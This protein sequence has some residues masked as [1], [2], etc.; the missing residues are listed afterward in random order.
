LNTRGYQYCPRRWDE[1]AAEL[2]KAEYEHFR[3]VGEECELTLRQ[4]AAQAGMDISGWHIMCADEYEHGY[5][6]DRCRPLTAEVREAVRE[7]EERLR[8]TGDLAGDRGWRP[9]LARP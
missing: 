7:Q 3:Q 2:A 8:R 5:G 9:T 1:T 4:V 6:P